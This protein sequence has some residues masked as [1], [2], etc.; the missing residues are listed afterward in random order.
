MYESPRMH[1]RLALAGIPHEIELKFW[2][3]CKILLP[4][5]IRI[6]VEKWDGDP[7]DILV[8][9]LD[10]TYGR[11]AYE[12]ASRKM[13]LRTLFFSESGHPGTLGA[14]R[15]DRQIMASALAALLQEMLPMSPDASAEVC[16]GLLGICLME[17]SIGHEL[18]A[19]NGA[20]SVIVRHNARRIYAHSVG[21]LLAAETRLLEPSWAW[22]PLSA[23]YDHQYQGLIFRSL[24][25]FLI[26]ACYQHQASLPR[27]SDDMYQLRVWPDLGMHPL[28][29]ASLR[30]ASALRRRYWQV[31][32]L[33]KHC[34]IATETVNAFAWATL[35]S[36]ALMA[37]GTE[38]HGDAGMRDESASIPSTI[39]RIARQFGL[40][41][42]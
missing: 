36:G 4:R 11:I 38:K 30:L 29:T 33:A 19:R 28:D 16:K 40:K 32:E 25:S 7:C 9:D 15:L 24:D 27:L 6:D 42:R 10:D 14:K 3:A 26:S 35:A 22:T 13:G 41:T 23:P 2:L 5:Q 12:L 37:I 1:A 39:R 21:D 20:A 18:L 17:E 34:G 8:A 31:E